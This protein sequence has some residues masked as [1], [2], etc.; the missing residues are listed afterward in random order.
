VSARK[1]TG[2]DYPAFAVVVA[3]VLAYGLLAGLWP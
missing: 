1:R 2:V 3:L